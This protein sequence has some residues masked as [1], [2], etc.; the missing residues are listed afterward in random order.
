MSNPLELAAHNTVVAIIIAIFV[1]GLTRIWRSPQFAHVLWLLV[2]LK[3]VTPP[4]LRIDL[5][6]IRPA[7]STPQRGPAIPRISAVRPVLQHR[8]RRPRQRP[9]GV[10]KVREVT[11]HGVAILNFDGFA[12]AGRREELSVFTDEDSDPRGSEVSS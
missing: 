6:G 2:L 3:L 7:G 1:Y 9:W 12:P 8:L 5:P 10:V 11:I 4:I